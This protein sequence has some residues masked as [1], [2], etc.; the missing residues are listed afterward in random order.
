MEGGNNLNVAPWSYITPSNSSIITRIGTLLPANLGNLNIVYTL[1]IPVIYNLADAVGNVSSL[2]ANPSGTCTVTL[3]PE[4]LVTLRSIDRCPAV[5]MGGQMIATD[6]SIC[7]T[8]RYEWEFTQVLP[9]AQPALT[10]LGGLNTTSLLLSSVPGMGNG[11]TYNVRVR[12]IHSSGKVGNYG[13][14]QCLKTSSSGMMLESNNG[15]SEIDVPLQTPLMEN[16]WWLLYPNPSQDGR[17]MLSWKHYQEG[18]KTLILRD[19]H[20]RV[21]MRQEVV[22]E[23]NFLELDW[24]D[25]DAGVYLFEVDGMRLRWVKS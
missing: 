2:T 6:R 5:K 18:Q 15:N 20:G 25:L 22:I 23:G 17:A 13:L 16:E 1:N 3:Q 10:V 4:A 14:S 24:K 12:P 21:I 7:G 9:T 19:V 8:A 11:K